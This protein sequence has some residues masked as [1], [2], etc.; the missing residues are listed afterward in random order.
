M[1]NYVI[2]FFQTFRDP[3]CHLTYSRHP[4][5][6]VTSSLGSTGEHVSGSGVHPVVL[7]KIGLVVQPAVFLIMRKSSGGFSNCIEAS[8]HS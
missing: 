2:H 4:V 1:G 5:S 3:T 6:P 8:T 7:F